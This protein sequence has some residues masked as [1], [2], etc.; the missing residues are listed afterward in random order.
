MRARGF[1]TD[2]DVMGRSIS[3]NLDYADKMGIPFVAVLGEKDLDGGVFTLKNMVTG[4]EEKVRLDAVQ[5]LDL[6][7]FA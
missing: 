5:D 7:E 3:K 4:E 1:N 2:V 6:D